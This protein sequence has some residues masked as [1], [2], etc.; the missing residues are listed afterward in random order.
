M[1]FLLVL[2]PAAVI[3][4][5]LFLTSYQE[6]KAG[7]EVEKA[8]H[9]LR[10]AEFDRDFKAAWNGEN[11]EAP[12]KDAITLA[13]AKLSAAEKKKTDLEQ[14]SQERLSK[15]TSELDKE[16]AKDGFTGIPTEEAGK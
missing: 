7:L 9:Q 5:L 8:R 3:G 12:E 14:E 10:S 6:N 2:G 16:L 1:K 4:L 13:K 11:L 15:M